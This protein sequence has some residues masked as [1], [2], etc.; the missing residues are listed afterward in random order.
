[1]KGRKARPTIRTNVAGRT[2]GRARAYGMDT[3]A[4]TFYPRFE[5]P[6]MYLHFKSVSKEMT[7]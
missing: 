1:M 3:I 7:E 4:Y 6:W 5:L 2:W